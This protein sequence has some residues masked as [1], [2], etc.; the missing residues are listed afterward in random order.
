MPCSVF[1]LLVFRERETTL[2]GGQLWGIKYN[3][4]AHSALTFGA[5]L[6]NQKKL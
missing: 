4:I 5:D 1:R 6:L 2:H 3:M